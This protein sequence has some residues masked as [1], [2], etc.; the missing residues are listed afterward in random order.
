VL[1]ASNRAIAHLYIVNPIKKFEKHARGL[2]STHQPIEERIKIL[3][4]FETGCIPE[5]VA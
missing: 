4:S 3:R 2:F 5:T 1:E